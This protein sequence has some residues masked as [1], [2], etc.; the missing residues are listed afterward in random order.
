MKI[1]IQPN[2]QGSGCKVIIDGNPV[3]FTDISDAQ[4]YVARLQERL[5]AASEAFVAVP[6]TT[7]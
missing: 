3:S 7:A 2:E 4:S 6:E 5:Q 1:E